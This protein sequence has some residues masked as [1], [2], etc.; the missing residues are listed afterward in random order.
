ME[1]QQENGITGTG[2][3]FGP[4]PADKQYDLSRWQV[5]HVPRASATEV[6]EHPRPSKRRRITG[7]PA[8]L[9]GSP[10]TGFLGPILTIY[11]AIPLAREALIWPAMQVHA[12][13]HS[14]DWWKGASDDNYMHASVVETGNSAKLD[15][16]LC[17]TQVLMAFLDNTHR[18]Y[19]S[20]ESLAEI[21]AYKD[22]GT[23]GFDKLLAVWQKATRDRS[24]DERLTQIFTSVAAKDSNLPGDQP[25]YRSFNNLDPP[26]SA[27]VGP[28]RTLYEILDAAIW[29]DNQNDSLDDIWLDH[30]ADILTLRLYDSA[31]SRPNKD[32]GI[33]LQLPAVF[34]ADRYLEENRTLSLERRR[35]LKECGLQINRLSAL[36]ERLTTHR[37]SDTTRGK[38][39][40]LAILQ[41][42][43]EA[44]EIALR[45]P[46][47]QTNGIHDD[48]ETQPLLA[49][50]GSDLTPAKIQKCANDLQRVID[51]VTARYHKLEDHKNAIRA[52]WKKAAKWLTSP[53][54]S[55]NGPPFRRYYLSGLS[56]KPWITYVR[57]KKGKELIEFE[58]TDDGDDKEQVLTNAD[59]STGKETDEEASWE[60]WRISLSRDETSNGGHDSSHPPLVGPRTQQEAVQADMA[61]KVKQPEPDALTVGY[62]ITRVREYEVLKAA[63]EATKEAVC[64]Y[65]SEAALRFRGL[66]VSDSLK[67]FVHRDNLAFEGECRLERREQLERDS[68]TAHAQNAH[69]H[70]LDP[71]GSN[72]QFEDIPLDSEIVHALDLPPPADNSSSTLNLTLTRSTPTLHALDSDVPPSGLD[73]EMTPMSIS[74]PKRESE[75]D[76]IDEESSPKRPRSSDQPGAVLDVGPGNKIVRHAERL[77]ERYGN[78]ADATTQEEEEEDRPSTLHLEHPHEPLR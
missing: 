72:H 30:C 26:V 70:P 27:T 41:T 25:E 42:A 69:G 58:E 37:F 45:N 50:N 23:N 38:S 49:D 16:F 20:V 5:T 46:A 8:F 73:R 24:P 1:S 10:S 33:D 22:F 7:E 34:Y 67:A 60:W 3:Q 66:E 21:D 51:A 28:D 39:P 54:T 19:G 68:L 48:L 9:Y 47:L 63:K 56:T 44:T 6:M 4:A 61:K 13:G 2:Q 59:T 65:A 55:P 15:N 35:R 53:P 12:Y 40:I 32:S 57:V 11:H 78:G 74:S 52:E 29:T 71:N 62:S 64:V 43:K 14:P 17:Q 18:A 75:D 36:Q 76:L 31:P 77:M